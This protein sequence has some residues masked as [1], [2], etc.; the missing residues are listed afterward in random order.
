MAQ[1]VLSGALPGKNE[2]FIALVSP[3]VP[4]FWSMN[5]L[6][7][8]VD[9]VTISRISDPDL[10]ERWEATVSTLTQGSFYV[11]GMSAAFLLLCFVVLVKKR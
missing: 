3:F 2:G 1:V 4:S 7:A 6:A 8:T 11:V 9:L 10:L 5:S